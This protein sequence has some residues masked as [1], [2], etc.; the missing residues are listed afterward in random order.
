MVDRASLRNTRHTA[1]CTSFSPNQA[2]TRCAVQGG[3]LV[4][5]KVTTIDMNYYKIF[6]K[7]SF[8]YLYFYQALQNT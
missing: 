1:L 8:Y 2:D 5:P 7:M 3:G 6:T 4:I